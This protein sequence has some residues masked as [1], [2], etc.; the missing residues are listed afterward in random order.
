MHLQTRAA[1]FS[2]HQ[3]AQ[4][5]CALF[6]QSDWGT[7]RIASCPQ[8]SGAGKGGQ[9][10]P[11]VRSRLRGGDAPVATGGDGGW[12][13]L[14]LAVWP[15]RAAVFPVG[16]TPGETQPL[17]ARLCA[18]APLL[19][20][21]V[22][23]RSQCGGA[24][25]GCERTRVAGDS[26]GAAARTSCPCCTQRATFCRRAG[27]PRRLPRDITSLWRG[28]HRPVCVCALG[29]QCPPCGGAAGVHWLRSPPPSQRA[30]SETGGAGTDRS[31]D[32][33][34]D[35]TPVPQAPGTGPWAQRSIERGGR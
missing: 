25:R 24:H 32:R 27:R 11:R 18:S 1:L 8:V 33:G 20:L 13:L 10:R 34:W 31:R 14:L 3:A 29:W 9:R 30:S 2:G 35:R 15:T 28:T 23:S 4:S 21:A 17:E 26:E 5:G 6:L 16:L 19:L 12:V 22:S 7:K